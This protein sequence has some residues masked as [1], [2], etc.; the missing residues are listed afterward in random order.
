MRWPS[1][2]PWL[3]QPAADPSGRFVALAFAAPA[4]TGG[5]QVSDVW[6]LDVRSGALT[7]LPSMPAFVS[8]KAT[9]IAWTHD[10]RLVL[11]GESGGR[12]VVAVWRPG[13]AGPASRRCACLSGL[14]TATRSPPLG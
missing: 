7:Q 8:L 5:R 11:L 9:S 1:I 2:L 4:W 10:G 3:D 14:A 13:G 6:L 12:D